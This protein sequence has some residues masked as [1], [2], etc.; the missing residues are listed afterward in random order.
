MILCKILII[1][2]LIFN[3]IQGLEMD[4]NILEITTT[5]DHIVVY[6]DNS[7]K[8]IDTISFE[9]II[10]EIQHLSTTCRE[11][12]AFGVSLHDEIIA[13]KKTGLWIEFIFNKT[14]THNDM[15]FDS[16]LINIVGQYT[17]FNIIRRYNG[18]YD[19]RCFYIDLINTNL[20]NLENIL[21][22]I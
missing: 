1:F 4:N 7:I 17:G 10:D 20:S 19:G 14:I 9:Q 11:A 2:I 16:L 3:N 6:K 8:E 18:K 21:N 15:P 22:N 13:A 5:T 12:P